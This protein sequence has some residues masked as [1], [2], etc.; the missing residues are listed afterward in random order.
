MRRG[1]LVCTYIE[2]GGVLQPPD[3]HQVWFAGEHPCLSDGRHFAQLAYESVRRQLAPGIQ[4]DHRFS[5][6]P[7]G[8]QSFANHYDK[9]LHYVGLLEDQARVLEPDATARTGHPIAT[10]NEQ[11]VFRYA[12][13]A[14][15]RSE[16][17]AVSMRLAL[18]K[19]AIVGLGGSGGYVL[20]QTAKT[21]VGEIHLFDGDEFLQHNAFRA[22][23]AATLDQIGQR[24]PKV[25]YFRALYAPTRHGL[26]PHPYYIDAA[27][28]GELAGFD[29]VFLCVDRGPDRAL[30]ANFLISQG[31]PFV[32]IG[33]SVDQDSD[34]QKLDGLCRATLCTSEEND[35]FR[36]Y[37]PTDDDAQDALYRRNIQVADLNAI[38]AILAV[39]K[40]KQHFG[41]YADDFGAH[42]VTFG[43]RLMSLGRGA[44]GSDGAPVK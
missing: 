25:E 12:D 18:K 1:T 22:P 11:S 9:V 26:V 19:I 44:L 6:K 30:I 2:S 27:N 35:H 7:D 8:L 38:N 29:F 43:V 10:T 14:S 5:N 24:M 4:I 32:D 28:V 3:N 42:N 20:D 40:W 13:T 16:T 23:G 31:V 34:S 33:M 39:I 17:L 37:A 15:A 21:P 41:L 36:S